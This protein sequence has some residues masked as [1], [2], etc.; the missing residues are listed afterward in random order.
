MTVVEEEVTAFV[1]APSYTVVPVHFDNTVLGTDS[2]T[3]LETHTCRDSA[4]IRHRTRSLPCRARSRRSQLEGRCRSA[5]RW[6]HTSHSGCSPHTTELGKRSLSC[7]CSPHKHSKRGTSLG[8]LDNSLTSNTD[9]QGG[10]LV[11][12][13]IIYLYSTG[14][15]PMLTG[16]V[17]LHRCCNLGSSSCRLYR[18]LFDIEILSRE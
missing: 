7:D 1:E 9:I 8:V 11:S 16:R 13:R 15:R 6:G 18:T 14:L 4:G 17:Y 12:E 5:G 3:L 2:H 10:E